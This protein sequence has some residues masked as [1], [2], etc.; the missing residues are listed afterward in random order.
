MGRPYW[1][2]QVLISLVSFGVSL[3]VATEAKSN[4]S[5][6]QISRST[7]ERMRHQK[8]LQSAVNSG[9][10]DSGDVVQKDEIVKGY[11]Y[12]KG[13]YVIIEPSE[14][15]DLRVSSKHTIAVLNSS[16]RVN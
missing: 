15:D 16:T 2:G 13:Q 11:E 10:I 9:E 12:T 14:L 6:H 3:Y 8:V 5:F 7:G 4:I 1:S